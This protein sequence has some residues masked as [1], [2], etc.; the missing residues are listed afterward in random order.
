[1]SQS[2]HPSSTA[3]RRRTDLMPTITFSSASPGGLG[4]GYSRSSTP[5]GGRTLRS[6]GKAVSMLHLDNLSRPRNISR[7]LNQNFSPSPPSHMHAVANNHSA[8]H[9]SSTKSRQLLNKTTSPPST[10][11]RKMS[12]SMIHLGPKKQLTLMTSSTAAGKPVTKGKLLS[13]PVMLV[14]KPLLPGIL[15]SS[16]TG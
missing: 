15:L 8:Q 13:M 1:M 6:P 10:D 12:K 4:L 5:G 16:K 9:F 14:Q 7:N 11:K 2:Y 3:H